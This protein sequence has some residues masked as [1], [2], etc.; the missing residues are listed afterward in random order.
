[1]LGLMN[2]LVENDLQMLKAGQAA[3][4]IDH[5]VDGGLRTKTDGLIVG[6][7]DLANDGLHTLNAGRMVR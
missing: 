6:L 5:L 1:M 4:L 7:V 2:H 3:G